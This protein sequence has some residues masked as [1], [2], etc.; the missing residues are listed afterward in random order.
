MGRRRTGQQRLH[1]WL[2]ELDETQLTTVINTLT[3]VLNIANGDDF[4]Q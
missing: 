3:A 2:S 1:T 4:F